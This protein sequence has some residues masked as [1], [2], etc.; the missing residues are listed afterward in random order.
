MWQDI[1]EKK[2]RTEQYFKNM[3]IGR[4]KHFNSYFGFGIFKDNKYRIKRDGEKEVKIFD[5]ID[6]L[7]NAG[8]ILD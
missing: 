1:E 4:M 7:V 3:P 8:W 2:K 5:T 6:E